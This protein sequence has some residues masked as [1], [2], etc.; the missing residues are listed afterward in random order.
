MK[1]YIISFELGQKQSLF[2]VKNGLF[3]SCFSAKNTDEIKGTW[4]W[5]SLKFSQLFR[6]ECP[7]LCCLSSLCGIDLLG[8]GIPEPRVENTSI[9]YFDVLFIVVPSA[10]LRMNGSGWLSRTALGNSWTMLNSW[11]LF[12][13]LWLDHYL[14]TSDWRIFWLVLLNY[15]L[16]WFIM[17]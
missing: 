3:S 7:W 17:M 16:L 8:Q 6:E 12:S 13:V 5:G 14:F 11:T 9:L 10:H 1:F 15:P 2:Q 4:Y